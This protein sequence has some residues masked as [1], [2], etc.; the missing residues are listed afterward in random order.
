MTKVMISPSFRP[1][2]GGRLA[3]LV[4]AIAALFGGVAPA[5]AQDPI[6]PPKY[7]AVDVNGVD[8]IS[9]AMSV[10][11]PVNSIG[12]GGIGGL[13]ASK[14]IQSGY[15]I[16]SMYSYVKLYYGAS[17]LE[18][19]TVVLMG[20]TEQFWGDPDVG[21]SPAEATTGQLDKDA[22]HIVYTLA[23]G[24]VARYALVHLDYNRPLPKF[25][26][27][28]SVVYPSGEVL[29]FTGDLQVESSLGYFMFGGYGSGE[30]DAVAANLTQG[31]CA[32]GT[33]SGPTFANQ[34]ALGR[35]LTKS[36][37]GVTVTVTSPAGGAKT[38][39]L[40]GTENRVTSVTDGVGTWTYS[41]SEV[42]DDN[43]ALPPDGILTTTVT[44]PLGHTRVVK[45][46]MNSQH[47]ISDTN[48]VGQTTT[49]Q[50]SG[51]AT[52]PG[53][54]QLYQ[55]TSP[56]GNRTRYEFD[57]RL[58][59]TAKWNE[60]KAGSGL[61][62]TVVRAGYEAPWCTNL[63][64]CN[65]PLWIQDE[66]GAQTDFTYDPAHG[67]VLTATKPAGP[68]GVRPQT[69][70][71]Y[72]Q[73]TARYYKNGVLTAAPPV[74]RVTQT[75]T[76]ATL[77]TC[78]GTADELVT[79]YAYENSA[80]ANN[81]RLL[82]TTTR[83]GNAPAAEWVTA[84]YAY[85][86]RGDVT[87][88][89]GPLPGAEDV[90]Q[91]YYDASRWKLGEVGP[92][93]DGAG[94]LLH[95]AG[96]TSYRADGR[97]ST[98]AIGVVADRSEAAF[99]NA[100]QVLQ[101]SE[102][103]YDAQGRVI[104]TVQKSMVD[105]TLVATEVNDQ[106]Y[107][108]A[109]RPTCSAVRMNPAAFSETPGACALTTAGADGPDRITLTSYDNANRPTQVLSGHLAPA[110]YASRVE[111]TATY[112]ANGLEQTVAD[113][114]GNLTTYEYDGLDRL[115]KVRYPNPSG[116]GSSTTDFE[117]Y[118]YDVAGN[119][120]N[121]R[122]RDGTTVTF[123]YDA[124][125]RA[126]NGLRG[127]AYAYDNL[128]RRTSATLGDGSSLATYDALGRMTS[129]TLSRT[130]G[131]TTDSKALAY[132]Y[133]LAGRRTRMTWPGADNFFVTYDY[134]GA[135]Q[136]KN[137]W[138]NDGTRVWA[139][140]Y[141]N[142]GRRVFGWSGPGSP[143]TQTIYGYDAASRLSALSH[144]LAG[145]AQDQTWTFAYTA[146]GQVKTRIATNSL[147][148]WSGAQA[149]KGYTVN[150]LN[151]HTTVAGA[152]LQYDLRGNLQTNAGTTYGYDLLNNLTSTS[153]GATLTY[154]P[155]GR[156][157]SLASGGATTTF[158]YSGSDLVA[159]YNSAGTL[160]RRYVPGPGTDEPVVWYEGAGVSD[161]RF[162]LADPQGSI[163]AVT[164]SA[165]ASIA[166]NTYDEYGIP[167][168]GNLGRFQYTGQ[169]WIPEVGLYHYKARAYSP[170]LGRFLQTDPI[171]YEDGLNWYAYAGND[172]LNRSDPTG[173]MAMSDFGTWFGFDS[174]E[175]PTTL[176]PLPVIAKMKD[177]E[178]IQR[179]RERQR[180]DQIRR[181]LEEEQEKKEKKDLAC[182]IFDDGTVGCKPVTHK[183]LCKG[184]KARLAAMAALAATDTAIVGINGVI[185]QLKGGVVAR[186]IAVETAADQVD[187]MMYCH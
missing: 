98:T 59:V 47:I 92:D 123:T 39:T 86:V 31:G 133:D 44:D 65:K 75:S 122:R 74:W 95:R 48:G 108:A 115:V 91:V 142:L 112:T 33:C 84:T 3:M 114:K 67:G 128:D 78:A 14:S 125:N 160:L 21:A 29:T 64:T 17:G 169:A 69:R 130:T 32:A 81:V 177:E 183:D 170:T 180:M 162:L 107:D 153:A 97:P 90:V 184:A 66:R 89:D 93:P 167:A 131:Q 166:T 155:T 23:D 36:A 124:L 37:T 152:A 119:R 186:L 35:S 178:A 55:I 168:A 46:R 40:G 68:N 22:T 116:P 45:S 19:S 111:K 70:Y 100:F 135:G 101:A 71:A 10:G 6:P 16:S 7:S 80:V 171:G 51:D 27:L 103:T 139:I 42:I 5:L 85:N 174:K 127:E 28:Q 88:V 77:A 2:L 8:L 121:W 185:K 15:P 176:P 172:P 150:G 72:G 181:Y 11:Q 175:E 60:P 161:R 102:P 187:V 159:E 173:L 57:S 149:T 132:Q 58:N 20:Q 143:A 38:Y 148:E 117:Q 18:E 147:Y 76:C 53:L 24:T 73:F 12:P 63:K 96:K 105:A 61:A 163:V 182:G 144:D 106:A 129:E 165:G 13:S 26:K 49:F 82:S 87:A 118:G 54:G 4:L 56:E 109:G 25:G 104:R 145:T 179:E 138:Q 164:N 94:A 151:Q 50:Y 9:G 62:A 79:T 158:L 30:W 154:E 140:A 34:Q 137:I 43:M 141:D 83:A 99:T 41:Y 120:T 157:W 136:M 146:V 156:L 134:D 113:G 126:G 1:T 52:H 110:G